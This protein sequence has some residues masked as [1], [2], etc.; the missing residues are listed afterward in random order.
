MLILL[1]TLL[2]VEKARILI[3][4][5]WFMVNVIVYKSSKMLIVFLGI[6]SLV[7]K[8]NK[9]EDRRTMCTCVELKDFSKAQASRSSEFKPVF[10]SIGNK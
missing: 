5:A 9:S 7:G 2:F 10:P 8:F 4:I 1:S 6:K 3:P